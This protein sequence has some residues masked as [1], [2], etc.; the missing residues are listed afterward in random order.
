M[1]QFLR[2]NGL[3]LAAC[4][5]ILP[6]QSVAQPRQP[7]LWPAWT[8]E[9]FF[10]YQG[11]PVDA[12]RD[13]FAG[14][15]RAGITNSYAFRNGLSL[16]TL[17]K[18]P[19]L[20]GVPSGQSPSPDSRRCVIQQV[21]WMVFAST[22]PLDDLHPDDKLMRLAV[23]IEQ[24][25][26]QAV[27][28]HLSFFL[29]NVR[30]VRSAAE[31]IYYELAVWET[32][33]DESG[34][35]LRDV[36]RQRV[37]DAIDQILVLSAS[38]ATQQRTPVIGIDPSSPR[39]L[40]QVSEP[41]TRLSS[42]SAPTSPAPASPSAPTPSPIRAFI[43]YTTGGSQCV[44]SAIAVNSSS[45]VVNVHVEISLNGHPHTSRD[46]PLNPGEPYLVGCRSAPGA[47]FYDYSLS[48]R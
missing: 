15:S 26:A 44:T 42:P 30:R 14:V 36:A 21:A 17:G 38:S 7:V 29:A 46:F 35:S 3:V 33:G 31:D 18:L 34:L 22:L 37:S 1:S 43:E 40:P 2:F 27:R 5:A 47:G 20:M 41:P 16:T 12:Y 32:N 9:C 23:T 25:L 39:R 48:V 24:N 11:K 19:D 6:D 4:V 10:A 45:T 8:E 13:M 28:S